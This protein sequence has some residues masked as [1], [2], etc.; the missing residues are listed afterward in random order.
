MTILAVL[1]FVLV[2]CS[3]GDGQPMVQ[4]ITPPQTTPPTTEEPPKREPTPPPPSIPEEWRTST[5]PVGIWRGSTHAEQRSALCVIVPRGDLWCLY[6]VVGAPDRA[7]GVV[8]GKIFASG[9]TWTMAGAAYQ[10]DTYGTF[11]TIDAEGQWIPEQRLGGQTE[12]VAVPKD[13]DKFPLYTNDHIDLFYD[14]RSKVPFD[15]KKAAGVYFGLFYPTEEVRFEL[16]E[17]GVIVGLTGSGCQF[18]GQAEQDGP[19]ASGTVTFRGAPCQNGTDTVRGV[20]GFDE[21]T[22]Q[23]YV[24]GFNDDKDLALFFNGRK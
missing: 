2:G 8:H 10:D 15:L 17:T 12:V 5:L 16:R 7:G 19:I 11:A 14:A 13:H 22:G 20:L 4:E 9:S 6:G 21:R 3:G 18:T 1:L 23:I 24:A